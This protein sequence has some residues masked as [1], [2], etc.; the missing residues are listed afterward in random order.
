MV[1]TSSRQKL[2]PLTPPAGQIDAPFCQVATGKTLTQRREGAKKKQ[3]CRAGKN[4]HFTSSGQ[5]QLDQSQAKTLR[6][7]ALAFNSGRADLLFVKPAGFARLVVGWAIGAVVA[8]LL[9]TETVGG[10]NPSL[11]TISSQATRV[12]SFRTRIRCPRHSTV[13]PMNELNQTAKC[14]RSLT[15]TSQ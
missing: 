7:R 9:Y 11:P 4:R 13:L 8:Q 3:K 15:G 10:S 2:S 12:P 1:I 14:S 6:P 5:R